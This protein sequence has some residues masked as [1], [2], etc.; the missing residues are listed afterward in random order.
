[1]PVRSTLRTAPSLLDTDAVFGRLMATSEYEMRQRP[2]GR[3]RAYQ[4]FN[5][6]CGNSVWLVTYSVKSRNTLSCGCLRKEQISAM[7]TTH[8]LSKTSSYRVSLNKARRSR[9]RASKYTDNVE[10][11]NF[12]VLQD[13]LEEHDNN[14]YICGVHLDVVQW[15]HVHPLSKGGAHVRSNL[16]P[17]CKECNSRKGVSHPFTKEMG[18]SIA[19]KVRANRISQAHTMPASDGEEVHDVC[20]EE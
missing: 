12:K 3:N 8:G 7:M 19:D 5:C 2:D 10:N 1:M 20:Q 15:D 14:C 13:I 11:I 4:K 18:S 9:I 6:E 16:R 17:S